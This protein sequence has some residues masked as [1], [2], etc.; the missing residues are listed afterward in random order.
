MKF[1]DKLKRSDIISKLIGNKYSFNIQT[2]TDPDIQIISEAVDWLKE[3]ITHK[4]GN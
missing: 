3:E 1:I 4:E 2:L